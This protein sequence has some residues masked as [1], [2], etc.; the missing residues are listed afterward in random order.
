MSKWNFSHTQVNEQVVQLKRGQGF[1][2]VDEVKAEI[3]A[4]AD[5]KSM[6]PGLEEEKRESV[7]VSCAFPNAFHSFCWQKIYATS[8]LLGHNI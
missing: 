2:Q 7:I 5:M 1:G 6:L 4:I 3:Y 8:S